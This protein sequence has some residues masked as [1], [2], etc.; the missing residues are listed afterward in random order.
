MKK[1]IFILT[2]LLL[3][4]TAAAQPHE[5]RYEKNI[6]GIRAGVNV[7]KLEVSA[8]GTPLSTGWRSGFYF[9]V[10][11]QILVTRHLPLYIETGVGFSSRGGKAV[12][13]Q[14]GEIYA[15]TL[16]PFYLQ[17]PLLVNYR[18][19]IRN[20]LTI[21]PFAGVYGGVG[22]RG[23]MKTDYGK[24]ELFAEPAFLRR[25]DFGIRAGVGIVVRRIYLGVSY[26]F[27][28]VNQ[29]KSGE[30]YDYNISSNNVDVRNDCLTVSI[31]YNF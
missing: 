5:Q 13:D 15:T 19:D 28:C 22:L 3:A 26:D 11:D 14:F 25:L 10:S 21:E 9:A 20:T 1:A 24:E 6:L 8:D 30:F 29:L 18:F 31:G 2:A 27:G 7:S 23:K 17:V 16:N 4:G 12:I